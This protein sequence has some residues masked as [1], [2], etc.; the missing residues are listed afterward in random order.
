MI[1]SLKAEA[2]GPL[3]N[4][5]QEYASRNRLVPSP[6]YAYQSIYDQST[7]GPWPVASYA[8]LE[9]V[10]DEIEIDDDVVQ[11][12]TSNSVPDLEV[13]SHSPSVL[14]DEC[15]DATGTEMGESTEGARGQ[16]TTTLDMVPL[17]AM[18]DASLRTIPKPSVSPILKPTEPI[19]HDY[20]LNSPPSGLLFEA[21]V[22]I[23]D[24]F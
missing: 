21:I 2:Q 17:D 15:S 18:E 13:T 20:I 4:A 23:I 24:S 1:R 7:M 16:D 9:V 22:L 12:E 6:S 3:W 8:S 5:V 11:P 14:E 10:E 19:I